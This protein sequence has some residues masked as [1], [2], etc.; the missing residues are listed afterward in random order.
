MREIG[1]SEPNLQQKFCS[2]TALATCDLIVSSS[3]LLAA[4]AKDE[5]QCQQAKRLASEAPIISYRG[6]SKRGHRTVKMKAYA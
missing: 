2:T 5:E 3:P 1:H 4:N 6:K